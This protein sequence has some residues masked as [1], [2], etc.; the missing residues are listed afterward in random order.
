MAETSKPS[1]QAPPAGG[2]ADPASGE[3]NSNQSAPKWLGKRVGRFRLQA[4]IGQGAMGRVFR[5]DDKTLQRRVALKVIS[6][7]DRNGQ[8]NPN[9]QRFITEAR[10][11]AALEHPHVVQIYEAGEFGKVCYIAMELLEGGSL[12]ELVDA[13]GPLD[14]HRAC[15]LTAEAAEALAAA[16]AVGVI[17]RDVKPANLMLSRHGRC[18]VTDFGLAVIDD[19]MSDAAI[20]DRNRRVGTALFVAPEVIRG[21]C[22]DAFS[23]MYSLG[24]TLF[25]L[26]TGR[27]PF[28][29]NGR[30]GTMRAHLEQPVPDLR[31]FRPDLPDGLAQAVARTMD[32]DPGKRFA[33]MEQ[34]SRLLRVFTIP[35][36]GAAVQTSP[37]GSH[38]P[39]VSAPAMGA[40]SAANLSGSFASS[41]SLGG[42]ASIGAMRPLTPNHGSHSSGHLQPAPV[43]ANRI[44]AAN[45]L[46]VLA[47]AVA[48]TADRIDAIYSPA[49]SS[50]AFP[51]SNA[52]HIPVATIAP[53]PRRILAPMA[54]IVAGLGLA[55]IAI[56]FYVLHNSVGV[57]TTVASVLRMP[58]PTDPTP[59]VT[60]IVQPPTPQAKTSVAPATQPALPPPAP[61]PAVA[62]ASS[63]FAATA[64][65]TGVFHPWDIDA[66]RLIADGKDPAHPDNIAVVQGKVTSAGPSSTGKVFHIHFQGASGPDAFE[67][68]Y[69]Q[70]SGMFEK[71]DAAFNGSVQATLPGKTVRIS[72]KIRFYHD[73]TAVQMVPE[74]PDR[75]TIIENP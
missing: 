32:K 16:H 38:L 31:T 51:Y 74:S 60:P 34:F 22:A 26:L 36:A 65:P 75:V 39:G 61:T 25:Y 46:A 63:P 9:A 59:I 6:L 19:D 68:V 41:S 58:P 35:L 7:Y 66:L 52:A 49:Q 45:D 50:G 53:R 64:I 43:S 40:S 72:G 48:A 24:A 69:F 23:D 55:A 54:G 29:A 21:T 28:V 5:A 14:V 4:L 1:G 2:S 33:S 11:A 30:D 8:I 37:A 27:P 42:I 44:A 57:K 47:Q 20:T 70:S 17:H 3:P 13:S 56:A 10:A 73:T 62:H 67:V 12:A 15:Q 71:M 18:K